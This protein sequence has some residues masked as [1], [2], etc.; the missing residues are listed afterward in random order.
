MSNVIKAIQQIYPDI[1]EGY[2]YW[3]TKYD[4]SPL[5]NP[6]DGLVW[7]NIE[8]T[9]PSWEEIEAQFPSV[10]LKDEQDIKLAQC[11][12]YLNKTDWYITRLSD[13]TSS[14]PVPVDVAGNRSNARDFQRAIKACGSLEDLNKIIINF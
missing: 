4:G 12:E 6:I 11:L 9:Q 3:E 14:E 1:K 8:Y 5:D 7:E 13:P 2:T 10:K